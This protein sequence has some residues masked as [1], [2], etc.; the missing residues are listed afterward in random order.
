[1]E[2][3]TYLDHV[4]RD[5]AL[6]LAAARSDPTAPV[7]SCPEWDMTALL[8]HTGKVHHWVAH[9]LETGATKRPV[10]QF[11]QEIPNSFDKCASW[12]ETGVAELLDALAATDP[13][14]LV[15]NWSADHPA[16]ARWWFRRMAHETT[17]HRWDAQNAVDKAE[18]INAELA[19][20]GIDEYLDFVVQWLRSEPI[21]GFEGCFSLTPTDRP[22]A[23]HLHLASDK[24]DRSDDAK[25]QATINAPV[26]DLYLWLLGRASV[27]SP[28]F[29]V[30]GDPLVVAKWDLIKFE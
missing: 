7:P 3:E 9:I 17:S 21:E 8:G 24:L 23:W 13:D 6:L 29:N 4:R 12:Y 5:G 26:S 15:W 19:A 28:Q 2:L 11:G 20:D 25:T 16:P 27:D 14:A 18:D 1:M 30:E 10:R 22:D